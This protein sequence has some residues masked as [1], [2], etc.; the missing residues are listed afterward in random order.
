MQKQ[1]KQK[2]TIFALKQTT[3]ILNNNISTNKI[4]RIYKTTTKHLNKLFALKQ[5]TFIL[6][7]HISTHKKQQV[8]K[9]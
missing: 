7:N 8:Y 5:T 6:N 2:Q 1:H 9:T 4:Q 3:F